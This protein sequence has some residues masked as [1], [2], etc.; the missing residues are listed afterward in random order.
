MKKALHVFATAFIAAALVASTAEAGASW[1]RRSYDLQNTGNSGYDPDLTEYNIHD[2]SVLHVFKTQGYVNATPIITD[3]LLITGDWAG[4]IYVFDEATQVQLLK[5]PTG[6]GGSPSSGVTA[7]LGDYI[8]MQSTP[9]LATVTVPNPAGGTREEKRIYVG[10][11]STAKTLWCLNLTKIIA[12][13]GVLDSGNGT[14]YFCDSPDHKAWPRSLAAP[15]SDNGTLNGALMFSQ[16]QPIKVNGKNEIRDVLYVPSTGLDCADGQFFA[17]DAYTGQLLWSF[18][19]VP[20]AGGTIWTTPA[21]NKARTLVFVTTGDCVQQPQVGAMAESLVALDAKTGEVVWHH[22]RRLVDT[23]DLDIGNGPLVADVDDEYGL[24]NCHVVVSADKDGCIY[25]FN[26]DPDMPQVGDPDFDPL[27]V[28]QQR[29][30]YRK[31]FVPGSLNGGFNASNM[32]FDGFRTVTAQASGYPAGH[33]GADDAN[34]FGMDACTGTVQWASSSFS[35]GRTDGA[36][37]S[38]LLFQLGVTRRNSKPAGSE[39]VPNLPQDQGPDMPYQTKKELVVARMANEYTTTPELLAHVDLPF[40][41]SLGGGG[42]A[43]VNGKVYL[44]TIGGVVELGVVPGSNQSPPLKQGS[45]VFAGPYPQP[46]AP[47]AETVGPLHPT[48]PYPFTDEHPYPLMIDKPVVRCLYE[49]RYCDKTTG[50]V[51]R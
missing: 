18:D 28:D 38:G 48:A 14:G 41:P 35:N 5:I 49:Y 16:N 39:T 36:V 9:T 50:G 11:N 51:S 3:G 44:P 40:Q 1:S 15:D 33:I 2:L 46:V 12:N 17:I 45:E 23:A 42:P 25:G 19:P 13:R 31:C 32:A 7:E 29:V 8:G 20:G 22:Q 27:R 24:G 4:F 37:A 26:Q 34:V 30:L 10:V 43:I 47:G 6:T 21:M